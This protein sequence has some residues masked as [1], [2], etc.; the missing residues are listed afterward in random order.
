MSHLPLCKHPFLV[1]PPRYTS[2][3]LTPIPSSYATTPSPNTGQTPPLIPSPV[4]KCNR[5]GSVL[6][7]RNVSIDGPG[8]DNEEHGGVVGKGDSDGDF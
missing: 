8:G 3:I 2:L 7:T 5:R 6:R 1:S 4:R